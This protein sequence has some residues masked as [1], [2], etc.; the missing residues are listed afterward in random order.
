MCGEPGGLV[1]KFASCLTHCRDHLISDLPVVHG[2]LIRKWFPAYPGV[3]RLYRSEAGISW[4]HATSPSGASWMA[5]AVRYQRDDPLGSGLILQGLLE[6]RHLDGHRHER[7][8]RGQGMDSAHTRCAR[9]HE[10]EFYGGY[11]IGAK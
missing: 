1:K 5:T 7:E 4:P 11:K 8:R 3:L 10:T 6:K 2:G 9:H